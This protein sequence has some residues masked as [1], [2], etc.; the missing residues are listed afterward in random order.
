[1]NG[2]EK[3]GKMKKNGVLLIME[4]EEEMNLIKFIVLYKLI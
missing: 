1:M 3:M 2:L 4:L